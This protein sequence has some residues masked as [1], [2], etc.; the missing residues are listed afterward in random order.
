MDHCLSQET[1]GC[2]VRQTCSQDEAGAVEAHIAGCEQCRQR[3]EAM[4][5][6]QPDGI[7][8]SGGREVVDP[9]VTQPLPAFDP[10]AMAT[11]AMSQPSDKYAR[12]AG[13]Q[14]L[15]E[16]YQILEELPQGGQAV[17]Y[18]AVHKATRTKVALKV[19]L[20]SLTASPKARPSAVIV[21]LMYPK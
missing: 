9:R 6:G 16:G 21:A 3:V 7:D 1:I 17:V 10:D 20:P 8:D 5:S 19:L 12:Q 14:A 15:F 13:P 2:Y 11:L 4:R 18:K